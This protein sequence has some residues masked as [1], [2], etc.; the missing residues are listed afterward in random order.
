MKRVLAIVAMAALLAQ[1][2]VAQESSEISVQS[3]LEAAR[4]KYWAAIAEIEAEAARKAAEAELK[5]QEAGKAAESRAAAIEKDF[6]YWSATPFSSEKY[7]NESKGYTPFLISWVPGVSL[8]FGIWDTSFAI[9]SIGTIARDI[10]GFAGSGVFNILRD[11]DGFAGAG[12]FNIFRDAEGFVGAGVFNVATGD[13]GGFEGAGVF[14]IVEGSFDGFQ[15]AGVFNITDDTE[16]PFQ[17]AGV[18]NISEDIV[19]IQMAGVFNI[20]D[21]VE[22]AQFA[23]L[24]N[25]GRD[26]RGLQ[27][28][29]VNVADEIHGIQIGL[30]NIARNGVNSVG[31]YYEPSTD[32]AYGIMQAGTTALYTTIG[33]GQPSVN[34]F[35]TMTDPIVSVGFGSRIPFG[36]AYI[37]VDVSAAQAVA[38]VMGPFLGSF[39]RGSGHFPFEYVRP[40]PSIKLGLGL[41]LLGRLHLVG[42]LKI[43]VDLDSAPRVPQALRTG[44]SYSN[45]WFGVG[46]TAWS[47]WYFG[48][49]I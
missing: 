11:V 3:V 14:N 18:F 8:P 48:V 6:E 24:F 21:D 17:G 25:V 40:Y 31:A 4:A 5:A 10:T 47:K 1:A 23:G 27:V 30:V 16:A 44:Y 2:V 41:P 19:G 7:P 42:G 32:Y 38:D 35:N 43:D 49:K 9:G 39:E 34:W 33:L 45:T 28:G 26:V 13:V 12:V 46:F 15:A 20:A 22:G 37:D 29:V 36:P